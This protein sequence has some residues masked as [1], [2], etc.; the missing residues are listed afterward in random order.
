VQQDALDQVK[1]W[2]LLGGVAL[3]VIIGIVIVFGNSQ[4]S[5]VIIIQ[6]Y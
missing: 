5:E 6:T 1:K 3:T 2:L 4:S